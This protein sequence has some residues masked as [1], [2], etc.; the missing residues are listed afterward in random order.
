MHFIYSPTQS[1]LMV[2]Y[3]SLYIYGAHIVTYSPP[4]PSTLVFLI[5]GSRSTVKMMGCSLAVFPFVLYQYALKKKWTENKTKQK[6][7]PMS[8]TH[9]TDIHNSGSSM[10]GNIAGSFRI[11]PHKLYL[12]F[13]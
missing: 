4:L 6:H 12:T 1:F 2:C 11:F 7:Y 8:S 13:K 10:L 9:H 5:E 3:Y